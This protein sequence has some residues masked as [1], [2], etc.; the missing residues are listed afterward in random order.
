M[1]VSA[2]QRA[3]SGTVQADSMVLAGSRGSHGQHRSARWNIWPPP[4][5]L[6][7]RPWGE[8]P[9]NSWATVLGVWKLGRTMWL[10][11]HQPGDSCGWKL[12][13]K[14]LFTSVSSSGNLFYLLKIHNRKGT[15][16]KSRLFLHWRTLVRCKWISWWVAC[17]QILDPSHINFFLEEFRQMEFVS[18]LHWSS[19]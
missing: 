4:S 18:W 6:T 1:S 11:L 19:G 17:K 8:C 14:T 16:A 7:S 13:Q 2:L 15:V 12:S 3:G 9:S 5:C 10:G